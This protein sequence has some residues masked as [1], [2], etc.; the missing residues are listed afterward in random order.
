MSDSDE[1][2]EQL[3]PLL[4]AIQNAERIISDLKY[5]IIKADDD[6][7]EA[8]AGSLILAEDG[9]VDQLA[10]IL[11]WLRFRAEVQAKEVW[12]GLSSCLDY[13]DNNT[14]PVNVF[15]DVF[16]TKL[17]RVGEAD[18]DY[19]RKCL[20][21]TIGDSESTLFHEVCK[22]NP[23][24]RVVELL[25]HIIPPAW[26]RNENGK[27][28]PLLDP[29]SGKEF[30]HLSRTGH[31]DDDDMR[32]GEYPIHNL[33]RHG[34]SVEVVKLLL[35]ADA[36][37]IGTEWERSVLSPY[38]DS[39]CK[40]LL[41]TLVENK[42]N[43]NP[44]VFS[45]ILRHL[46][47]SAEVNE[48]CYLMLRHPQQPKPLTLLW[49]SLKLEGMSDAEI[50]QDKDFVF[51]L[52]ATHYHLSLWVH[53]R[54][55]GSIPYED[56]RKGIEQ[57]PFP[58]SF[59]ICC[60]CFDRGVVEKVLEELY[61][62]DNGIFLDKDP[63]GIYPLHGILGGDINL[64]YLVEKDRDF[65]LFI[66]KTI[67]QIAPQCAQQ[68]DA[69]G[70]LPLHIVADSNRTSYISDSLRLSLVN[71]IWKAYPDAAST[72]DKQT[73]L[74]AFALPMRGFK[75]GDLVSSADWYTGVSSA[76]FLLR[77][78][79]EILAEVIADFSGNVDFEVGPKPQSKRPRISDPKPG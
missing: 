21:H 48:Q 63:N 41:H 71:T 23:P 50:L 28:H 17:S 12:T 45:E 53:K 40:P 8:L 56:M 30:N 27:G 39:S 44:S 35:K 22:R 60:P 49:K 4:V 66:I 11:D 1:S 18:L 46:I 6:T 15:W 5:Q 43:H 2:D 68:I 51:L 9:K 54:Y 32:G 25:L 55:R 65:D 69:S 76:Y 62:E 24:A 67:L 70:L 57:M 7:N 74:P 20:F 79:P 34:G 29:K 52:K 3:P 78:R 33:M 64:P 31:V 37:S 13:Y 59:L 38:D 10:G 77:Q 47:L 26:K 16:H 19:R 72:M 58:I 61:L 36:D 42:R 14:W 73:N 75:H